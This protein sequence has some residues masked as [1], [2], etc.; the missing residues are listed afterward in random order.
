MIMKSDSLRRGS[1]KARTPIDAQLDTIKVP[2]DLVGEHKI[3]VGWRRLV[4]DQTVAGFESLI[5]GIQHPSVARSRFAYID[6]NN[7][8]CDPRVNARALI[9]LLSAQTPPPQQGMDR[10]PLVG[11]FLLARATA[12]A[13]LGG[14]GRRDLARLGGQAW[15]KKGFMGWLGA[16]AEIE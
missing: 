2:D 1:L 13:R 4:A 6:L 5:L 7:A 15:R 9:E 14:D 12:V 3:L 11:A 10:R 8:L 16:K